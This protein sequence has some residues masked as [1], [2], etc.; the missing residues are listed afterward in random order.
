M[1]IDC[2]TF[3]NEYDLLEGR[4]NYLFKHVNYF[5]ITESN[6]TFSGVPKRFNFIDNISRYSQFLD[7]IIYIPCTPSFELGNQYWGIE[8]YQR[9]RLQQAMSYFDDDDYVIMGDV[10]E[11]PSFE[12][13]KNGINSL[14]NNIAS[15]MIQDVHYYNLKQRSQSR[16]Y[17]SLITRC[18]EMKVRCPQEFRDCRETY[19]P[20]HNGGWHLSH[21][22]GPEKIREKLYAG[23]HREMNT[24]TYTDVNRIQDYINRG[25]DLY[26]RPHEQYIPATPEEY[27]P[28]FYSVFSRYYQG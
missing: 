14:N 9:N 1:I 18:K 13:I 26:D 22:G 20:I 28:F 6:L 17:G 3:F 12:G 5:V 23:S 27:E 19:T 8:H 10:D 25:V 21:W 2:F 11:I 16:W 15:T 7:R 4:L 24:D